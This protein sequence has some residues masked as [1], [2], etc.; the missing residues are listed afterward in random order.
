MSRILLSISVG[1]LLGGVA[2]LATID[3][4]PATTLS[5]TR[6]I[7]SCP[8]TVA[9]DSAGLV[10]SSALNQPSGVQSVKQALTHGSE[11]ARKRALYDLADGTG[12]E[13]LQKLIF[14]ASQLRES[15]GRREALSIFIDRLTELDPRSALALARLDTISRNKTILQRVWQHWAAEDLESALQESVRLP[16]AFDRDVAVQAMFNAYGNMNNATIQRISF[17]TG[18]SP[19]LEN[20]RRYFYRLADQA[21]ASAFDH[22]N[23]MDSAHKQREAIVHLAHYLVQ[24]DGSRAA[25]YATL[26]TSP[27][28]RNQYLA[29][30]IGRTAELDPQSAIFALSSV[31]DAEK[32]YELHNQIIGRVAWHDAHL[33][34]QLADQLVD[35]RTRD[36]AYYNIIEHHARHDP[37]EAAGWAALIMNQQVR[38]Y[39]EQQAQ[40]AVER[41]SPLR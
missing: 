9:D 25:Q 13:T 31:D 11:F 29:F 40:R 14:D 5:S 12:S 28:H 17:V 32:R 21:P 24:R 37:V 4:R 10:R 16:D 34:K 38:Q 35:T 39:A 30:V 22:A 19:D 6:S 33:A 27:L 20:R 18:I 26:I 1:A 41:N 23:K 2:V 3:R 8:T 7:I 15:N 36:L